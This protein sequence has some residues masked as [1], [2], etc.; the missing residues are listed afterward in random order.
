MIA[1]SIND[2]LSNIEGK[3]GVNYIDLTTG[4]EILC[5]NCTVFPAS[6]GV[7]L[8]ALVECFRAIETGRLDE[9]M[10]TRFN[11]ADYPDAGTDS[12]GVLKYLHDGIEITIS[13]LCNLMITVSD[14]IAFNMLLDFLKIDNINE[15]FRSLGYQNMRVN[16]KI[17]DFEQMKK[18]VQNYISVREMAAIFQRMYKGQL[19]SEEASRRMIQLMI[20]HQRGTIIPHVLKED[21]EV[22]HQTGFDDDMILDGGIVFA[23]KPFVL[24]MAAAD[25]N[26]RKAESIMRDITSICYRKACQ[27]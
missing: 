23:D 5:G 9:N 27:N 14:N 13:D 25:T 22:A 11:R 7:M 18:G 2:R 1:E 3:F 12:F 10:T 17:Y 4:Q 21:M 8:M 20:Q 19:I 26:I 24:V 6:G 16:R 15:T